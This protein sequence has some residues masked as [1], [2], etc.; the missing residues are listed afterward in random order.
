MTKEDVKPVVCYTLADVKQAILPFMNSGEA[1]TISCELDGEKVSLV[2]VDASPRA[3]LLN[4]LNQ[5]KK[6]IELRDK[7]KEYK[8]TML[9]IWDV[10][11]S[12]FNV[13]KL[14][15]NRLGGERRGIR[16]RWE[17]K[18]GKYEYDPFTNKLFEVDK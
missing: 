17:I 5:V 6:R 14:I 18:E 9:Q 12:H 7:V 13:D 4:G 10:D 3:I 11:K 2:S 16:V 1:V 15:Y 8:D